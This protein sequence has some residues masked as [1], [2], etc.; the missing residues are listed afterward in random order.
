MILYFDAIDRMQLA[1][2]AVL[3]LHA[4]Y[5]FIQKNPPAALRAAGAQK[6][7]PKTRKIMIFNTH[8]ISV[9]SYRARSPG[10]DYS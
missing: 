5:I 3:L 2:P 9:F 10:C 8:N 1:N 6:T 4:Y 7:T